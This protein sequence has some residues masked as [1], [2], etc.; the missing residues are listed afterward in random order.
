MYTLIN[1][2]VSPKYF[3]IFYRIFYSHLESNKKCISDKEVFLYKCNVDYIILG[4]LL[5]KVFSENISYI[6]DI[7]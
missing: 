5:G 7:K 1:K 4:Y 2:I 3:S 6:G